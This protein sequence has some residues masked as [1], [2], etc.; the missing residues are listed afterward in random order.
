MNITELES[1]LKELRYHLFEKQKS[2]WERSLSFEDELFDRWE[3]ANF[4]GFGEKTSI[5]QSSLVYGDVK[6]GKNTWIG[7]YTILDG[8][9]GLEI[10]NNCSISSGVQIYTHDTVEKRVSNGFSEVIRE[11]T[12]IGNSCYIGPLSVIR[13]GIKINNNSVVSALSYV[14]KE[15]PSYTVVAGTPAK[16]IGKIKLNKAKDVTFI[17]D[18]EHDQMRSMQVEIIRLKKRLLHLEKQLEK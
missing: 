3:R 15:V 8:S 1:L 10:G 16:V 7:P 9:G 13:K 17:F 2:E 6:V 11:K 4:L 5:Y 18:K 14:N 12:T